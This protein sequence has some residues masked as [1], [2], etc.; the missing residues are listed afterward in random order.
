MTFRTPAR[1]LLAALGVLCAAALAVAAAAGLWLRREMVASLPQLDGSSEIRGLASPVKVARD[2]LGVPT[3][4]GASRIDVARATGWLHAQDRFFQM[5]VLRRRGAGELSELFGKAALPLDRTARMHGFRRVAREVLARESPAR[6]ALIGA[7]AE[8]V[9]AGLRALASRP[10]EYAVLRTQPRPWE[11]EDCILIIYAMTLDLQ[12]AAGRFHRSLGAVRDELGPASVAFFAP[13]ST[14]ADAALDGSV[15][16]AAPVPPASE[17]DVRGRVQAADPG[18]ARSAGAPWDDRESPGSNSFA[19]SGAH[20]AGS[21]AL[22]ANDMHLHLGVPNTWYR[23]ALRWPGHAETGVTLPGAPMLVA[24]STGK[25]AWGFTNSN[26]GTGDIVIVN[27]SISPDLY[28]GPKAAG[29]L[30]YDKRTENVAVRGSKPVAMEFFWTVWGPV[31]GEGS[32]GRQL[33]FHWT[34]DDPAATNL[35]ILDLEDASGVSDAVR[36]AH[37]MG[38]P[39]QN[40]VVADSAGQIAW[41]VAGLLPKRVGY[42]GRLPAAWAF[43]DRRWDGYLAPD[44]IPSVLSPPQGLIWTANNRIVGGPALEAL[45]DSGYDMPARAGQIRDDLLGLVRAAKPL[46]PRDLLGVQLDDRAVLLE[47]WHI[48]LV[49]ALSPAAVASKPSRAALLEAARRWDGRADT[50]SV[51]YGVVREFRLAVA[52]RVFDPIFAPCLERDAGFTW[53]RFNYEQALETILRERPVRLLDAAYGTWG[54]LLVAAA[55]DVSLSYKTGGTDPR[56]APWG[57]MNAA[58]IEHPFAQFLPRWASAWLSMPADPLAGDSNMPRVQHPS[59]GA[60][61][62][63]VVSPGHEDAGIFHMPGGECSNPLSPYFRAGHEAWVRGE[64][65]PFLPGPAEHTLELRP[66]G[67]G[68]E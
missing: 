47:K 2:A 62:R 26:A 4:T 63:F 3:V 33:V 17:V 51:A 25:V 8:G 18:T 50:G 6:R 59:F 49:D 68:R 19:V 21:A 15:L 23:M 27:P 57:A 61:E 60:S 56:T 41:T 16:A 31:V 11:P 40:F 30:A 46:E 53:T 44:S 65:T 64:P 13:L 58:R 32:E 14:A 35:N 24:G 42:D 29:L 9:N 39:A 43:G 36:I 12:E 37:R 67:A 5:D 28:H 52:K 22:V 45:G 66:S 10:W 55:D 48:L 34:E 7:Y 54:D 1:R 20:A 38:I